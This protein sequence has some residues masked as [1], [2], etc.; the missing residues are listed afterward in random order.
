MANEMTLLNVHITTPLWCE[1]FDDHKYVIQSSQLSKKALWK[2]LWKNQDSSNSVYKMFWHSFAQSIL[3]FMH[4][5]NTY[6]ISAFGVGQHLY[7]WVFSWFL[8]VHPSFH[9]SIHHTQCYHS[10]FLTHWGQDKMADIF[11]MTFWNGL[12][13]YEFRLIFH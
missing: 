5:N 2:F 11:Q 9:L 8:S 13:M 3:K 6:L 10:N 7:W 4:A 12:K 1:R